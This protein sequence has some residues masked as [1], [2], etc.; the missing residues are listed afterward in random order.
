MGGQLLKKF[1][2]RLFLIQFYSLISRFE[3]KIPWKKLTIKFLCPLFSWQLVVVKMHKNHEKQHFISFHQ[4]DAMYENGCN[5]FSEHLAIL[6]NQ[7]NIIIGY[8]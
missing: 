6:L 8:D 5:L 1:R 4:N 7:F 3:A 2:T